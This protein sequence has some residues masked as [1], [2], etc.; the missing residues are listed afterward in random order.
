MSIKPKSLLLF[1]FLAIFANQASAI[2]I[3]SSSSTNADLQGL[4]WLS[5]DVTAGMSRQEVENST[6]ITSGEWRYATR[7][8]T[9]TLIN[10][11]WGGVYNGHSADN[12]PGALDFLTNWSALHV[13]LAGYT[14]PKQS[15]FLFGDAGD[16]HPL[17]FY[18]CVGNVQHFDNSPHT[19]TVTNVITGATE[20]P[21]VA[22]SGVVG[23]FSE[24]SGGDFGLNS[25]NSTMYFTNSSTSVGSL[26]VRDAAVPLPPT[27]SIF[28][29]GLIPLLLRRRASVVS[30]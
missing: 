10:S 1:I 8:E 15:S 19:W 22:N 2:V 4:E 26:L 9:E 5:L 16:C 13:S 6:L 20:T 25:I 24:F 12:A 18:I 27:L 28:L 7:S 29:L 23:Y 30:S 14:N 3:N 21:Y 11:L 17:P